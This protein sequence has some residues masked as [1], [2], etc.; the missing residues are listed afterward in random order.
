METIRSEL[1]KHPLNAAVLKGKMDTVLALVDAGESVN[2]ADANG[3][4]ALHFADF[5]EN[6]EMA[7]CLVRL[8]ADMTLK[9]TME[10]D[11]FYH[12]VI[13][14]HYDMVKCLARLGANLNT[15]DQHA[16]PMHRAAGLNMCD[17]VK[18]LVELGG[19]VNVKDKTFVGVSPLR[20]AVGGNRL[21]MVELLG[22]L[23]ADLN[24]VDSIG[25]NAVGMAA[26]DGRWEI[27][28]CLARLGADLDMSLPAGINAL[29][30]AVNRGFADVVS[31]LINYGAKLNRTDLPWSLLFRTITN[32]DEATLTLLLDGGMNPDLDRYHGMTPL[33]FSATLDNGSAAHMLINSGANVN[34]TNEQGMN[35]L[36]GS[37]MYG[38]TDMTRLLL[39]A[40]ADINKTDAKGMTPLDYLPF[41]NL[42]DYNLQARWRT[43]VKL[44]EDV[45]LDSMPDVICPPLDR[46]HAIPGLGDVFAI[47]G[48]L[49]ARVF[50][51]V[52]GVIEKLPILSGQ[53][54]TGAKPQQVGSSGEETRTGLPNEMDFI[55]QVDLGLDNS[56]V[57][58]V[59]YGYALFSYPADTEKA[60]AFVTGSKSFHDIFGDLFQKFNEISEGSKIRFMEGAQDVVKDTDRKACTPM[61]LCWEDEDGKNKVGVSV[62]AVPCIHINDWPEK[63]TGRTWLMDRA[64]L[65]ERGYNLIPKPPNVLSEVARG[66]DPKD[67]QEIWRISFSHLETEHM[68]K[69][70]PRVKAVYITAKCL[71]NPDVCQI[72]IRDKSG[73]LKTAESYV[74]SYLLKMMFFQRAEEFINIDQSLGKMV[75]Q[76]FDDVA[77]GLTRNFIPLF[78]IP[79]VNVLDGLKLDVRKCGAVARLMSRF[80]KALYTRDLDTDGNDVTNDVAFHVYQRD[81][82]LYKIYDIRNIGKSTEDAQ[83]ELQ[84]LN[85]D[86]A[87]ATAD[88]AEGGVVEGDTE[89]GGVSHPMSS[90][91][92]TIKRIIT[93]EGMSTS[94]VLYLHESV[95]RDSERLAKSSKTF[96][97]ESKKS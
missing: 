55:F 59:G 74:V 7:E 19:D 97:N 45:P 57:N 20:Y 37:C 58:E 8:G 77:D 28:E 3:W 69:V 10:M 66:F 44:V 29:G 18:L 94:E 52:K 30:F 15:Y 54:F 56:A 82:S 96:L 14:E 46:L 81:K 41:Q 93:Q 92:A 78:F 42:V 32:H 51:D 95:K 63:G 64:L 27:V 53:L 2:T 70:P 62:D 39:L 11:P 83:Q 79:S 38:H 72:L 75:C 65:K 71:R 49:A 26:S 33:F 47:P 88:V 84:M 91:L 6:I 35:S 36:H 12:A 22:Q 5:G 89:V 34:F 25:M 4:T 23:G 9:D 31:M 48:G 73:K 87:T 86:G 67:L 60:Y 68:Y 80:V 50:A 24:H 16:S 40:G 21:E 90:M 61:M 17:M 13:G 85:I 1:A 76:L 43:S